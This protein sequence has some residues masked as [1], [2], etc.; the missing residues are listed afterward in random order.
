AVAETA[1]SL[2]AASLRRRDVAEGEAQAEAVA[3]LRAALADGP[4]PAAGVLEAARA[5]G[6]AERTLRRA[7][8]TLGVGA[9]KDGARGGWWWDLPPRPPS[10]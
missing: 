4:Q 9:R 7:K 3:F 5:A 6:L 10:L 1:E 2:V 8:A